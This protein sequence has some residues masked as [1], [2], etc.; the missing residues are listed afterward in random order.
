MT[1]ELNHFGTAIAGQAC[2]CAGIQI[3][4]KDRSGWV[5]DLKGHH[6]ANTLQSDEGEGTRSDFANG[7]TLGLRAFGAAAVFACIAFAICIE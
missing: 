1:Q 2:C 3:T 7:N 6:T 4:T 5:G